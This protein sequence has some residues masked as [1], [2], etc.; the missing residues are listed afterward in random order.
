MLP[1]RLLI[2]ETLNKLEKI[3]RFQSFSLIMLAFDTKKELCPIVKTASEFAFSI[4]IENS[5]AD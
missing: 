4:S 1:A 2:G 5:A 3:I